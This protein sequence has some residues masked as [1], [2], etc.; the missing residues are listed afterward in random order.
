MKPHVDPR[1]V[2]L[3]ILRFYQMHEWRLATNPG[4][5]ALGSPSYSKACK[6]KAVACVPVKRLPPR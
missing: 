3:R 5:H 6:T 4:R 1:G 2:D